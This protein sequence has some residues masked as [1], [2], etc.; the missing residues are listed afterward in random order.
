MTTPLQHAVRFCDDLT[1]QKDISDFKG[2][3]NGL[4]IENS[5]KITKIGA[6]VDAGLE[7][8]TRAIQAGVDFLIVHHGI[9]WMPQVPFTDSIYKKIKTAFDGDLAVYSCH[10]PLDAHPKIGNNALLAQKLGL[11]VKKTFLNFEGNDIGLICDFDT[12]RDDL[13]SRLTQLFPDTY[14]SL[15]F[16][17]EKP[18]KIAILTG[19]GSSAIDHLS[20]EG[21]DT[22]ITGELRQHN[23]NQAQELGLNIF[24]CG[25]YATEVFG[26]QALAERLAKQ[27]SLD[28]EFIDTACPL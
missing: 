7:P 25:H 12:S 14:N 5:G 10:L 18:K 1:R 28:W 27:M 4:Q 6:S 17:S 8:F 21:V 2:A 9:F 20:T 26:V 11:E 23:F 16:G 3:E 24:P 13:S 19:S 22:L 15:S